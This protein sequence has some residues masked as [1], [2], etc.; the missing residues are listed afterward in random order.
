MDYRIRRDGSFL[1]AGWRSRVL[2]WGLDGGNEGSPNYVE[3][4]RPDSEPERYAFASGITVNKD[5]V[6]RVITGTGGG[7]GD[8]VERSRKAI[9]ADIR[10]GF[11]TPERAREVYGY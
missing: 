7:I 1:T 2:P 8:P 3:V 10:D 4:I 6:I 9:E 11:I 5:D